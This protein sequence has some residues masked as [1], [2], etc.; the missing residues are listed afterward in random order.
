MKRIALLLGEHPIDTIGIYPAL[1]RLEGLEFYPQPLDCFLYDFSGTNDQYDGYVF[2]CMPLQ[3]PDL[4]KPFGDLEKTAKDT[5]YQLGEDGKGITVLHH[6]LVA[7]RGLSMWDE[8]TGITDRAFSYYGDIDI[9]VCPMDHPIAKGI[10]PWMLKDETFKMRPLAPEC[11]PVLTT[12]CQYSSPVIAW[13]KE[14]RNARVFCF[15]QGHD[16]APFGDANFLEVLRRGILWTCK[17]FA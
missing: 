4:D 13:T 10:A 15:Q 16:A 11:R 8:V 12:D 14:Y 5:F 3:A 17:D 9:S 7:F 6:G 2:Y 1:R